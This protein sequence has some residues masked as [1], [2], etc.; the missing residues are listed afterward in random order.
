MSDFS[1]PL[2]NAF[3]EVF[4]NARRGKCFYHLKHNIVKKYT[5]KKYN[6][7]EEYLEA[8]GKCL[9]EDEVDFLWNLVK[10]D[11]LGNKELKDFSKEFVQYFEKYYICKENKMFYMGALPPGYSNTNNMLEGHHRHLKQ[12]IFEYKVRNISKF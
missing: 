9:S 10:K 6:L 3:T 8:L 4:P 11:I 5:K 2:A 7:L 12:N 1:E